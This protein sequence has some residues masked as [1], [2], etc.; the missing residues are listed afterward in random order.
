MSNIFFDKYNTPH[1]AF[2]FDRLKMEDYEPAMRR[3][4]EIEK[5][6]MERLVNNP[7]RPTFENTIEAMETAGQLLGKVS[8]IFFNLTSA[9]TNDEMDDLAEKMSPIL[10]DHAN[11]IMFDPRLSKRVKE[12]YDEYHDPADNGVKLS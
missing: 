3:G 11:D 5:E 7:E 8:G 10:S 6:E 12:V 9:D 2:P 4:M 1:N